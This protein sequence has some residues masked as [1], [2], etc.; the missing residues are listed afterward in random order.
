MFIFLFGGHP[1]CYSGVTF[2]SELRNHSWWAWETVWD[3]G[4]WTQIISMQGCTLSVFLYQD[5]V[6]PGGATWNVHTVFRKLSQS[7]AASPRLQF[8]NPKL[9][10]DSSCS[11][12]L[13]CS[14]PSNHHLFHSI[15][16]CSLPSLTEKDTS[17]APTCFDVRTGG[18]LFFFLSQ[19]CEL[20]GCWALVFSPPW[21]N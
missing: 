5:F 13:L 7:K 16:Y 21:W 15:T 4:D 1:H 11:A 3:A 14:S 9:K 10:G 19:F 20:K 6:N 2:Y 12:F 17:V 8:H 18:N